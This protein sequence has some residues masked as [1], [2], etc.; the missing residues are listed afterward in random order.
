MPTPILRLR[1][2]HKAFGPVRAL[3]G[4][5][6]DVYS[7]EV[8]GLV[9]ENGAGKSTLMKVLSGVHRPDAGR[10]ELADEPYVPQSPLD[11]RSAGISM[12]YQELA[13][14]PHLTVE[15][16]ITLGAENA[17][18]GWIDPRTDEVR[19][20][21]A[22]LGQEGIRPDT[23]VHTLSIGKQQLVEIGR[24]LLLK[25]R[26]VVMDEPTSSLAAA[27]TRALFDAI[28][29]MKAQ[30]VA[31]IYISHF[32]EE[33]QEICDRYTVIRDGEMISTG[34]VAE[35]TVSRII[36][37]MVGRSVDDL[38]PSH[39]NDIGEPVLTVE[40]LSGAVHYPEN[41]SF[42]LHRG[43]ILGIAGLVGAGRS[44]TVRALFGLEEAG[45]GRVSIRGYE[46]LRAAYIDPKTALKHGM[47]LLSENRNE[48]GLALNL[49]LLTNLT[50]SD[51]GRY[52]RRGLLRLRRERRDGGKWVDAL[53]IRASSVEQRADELSGG[54]QQKVCLARLLHQD[55]DVLFLDEPTR[56]IDIGSKA[57][58]YRLIHRLAAR[59]KAIVMISSYLPELLGMCD[60]LGVMFKGRLSP[61]R[62]IEEWTEH[63][64]MR[65]ATSGLQGETS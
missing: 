3:Q 23:P 4:V 44:E 56:G 54:N 1:D 42:T 20:I 16:N 7:G 29:R 60:S 6:M 50:L 21:L 51:L 17:S 52:S 10:M 57:E 41:V 30:G 64:I 12:I 24:A 49:S 47:D 9:G 63:A 46:T 43:E 31:V 55:N 61:V 65:F 33:V 36:E 11:G 62:P 32:L 2:I 26:V 48:E 40:G 59:G 5:S 19:Q 27:D 8:H 39:E 18:F 14:A 34:R 15:E 45:E 58:I 53:N 13:L 25:S 22:D 37:D 35:T 28:E 38:F